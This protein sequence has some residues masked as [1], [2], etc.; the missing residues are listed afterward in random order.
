MNIKGVLMFL[1]VFVI[2]LGFLPMEK[3]NASA[4]SDLVNEIVNKID[5]S[6]NYYIVPADSPTRGLIFRPLHNSPLNVLVSSHG[7]TVEN[8]SANPVKL[9]FS[10]ENKKYRIE[11]PINLMGRPVSYWF[12][13][14]GSSVFLD[15]QEKN[16][17]YWTITSVEGGYTLQVE[18]GYLSYKDVVSPMHGSLITTYLSK[19]EVVW[20]LVP[21]S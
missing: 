4:S 2:F 21:A 9:H 16:A 7:N 17:T 20:K 19:E 3:A 10:E 15:W 14:W 6:K 18:S 8:P 12:W 11:M 13:A 1:L 5:T